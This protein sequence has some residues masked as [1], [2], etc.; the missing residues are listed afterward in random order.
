MGW[1]DEGIMGGDEPLDCRH[2]FECVFGSTDE[3]FN[4]WRI[5]DGEE[6]I[7]FHIP[8]SE[9]TIEFIKSLD[10]FNDHIGKQVVGWLVIE[11]G[12]PMNDELRLLILEGIDSEDP[13]EEGWI[14]PE[15][16]I[17]QLDE[18]RRI[19]EAY[20]AEGAKVEMP[21]SP[22]LFDKIYNAL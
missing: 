3:E 13:I 10:G 14:K 22:G 11:R 5:E 17:E 4:E 20:P 6:P 1:W 21:E 2:V 9:E 19:V 7:P 18:F 15:K 8:T 16:R 12:A